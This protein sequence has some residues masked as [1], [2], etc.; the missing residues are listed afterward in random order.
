MRRAVIIFCELYGEDHPRIGPTA[1]RIVRLMQERGD[2]DK[3]RAFYLQALDRLPPDAPFVPGILDSMGKLAQQE[4]KMEE[5][6]E[7][8][9]RALAVKQSPLGHGAQCLSHTLMNLGDLALEGGNASKAKEYHH[10]ALQAVET[11]LGTDDVGVAEPLIKLSVIS[12]AEG[13]IGEA[14][15]QLERAMRVLVKVH[16]FDHPSVARCADMVGLVAAEQGDFGPA[17]CSFQLA[18]EVREAIDEGDSPALANALCQLV[19]LQPLDQLAPAKS[20]L[21]RARD[22]YRKTHAGEC[23]ALLWVDMTLRTI[24]G[25]E[26]KRS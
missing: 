23:P 10:R 15:A 12:F 19:S 11:E 25:L 18:V 24:E 22:I 14:R 21:L 6:Q 26:T 17:R 4:G 3:A 20:M 5:A 1:L 13:R 2:L 9:D 7:W 8:L 16:G